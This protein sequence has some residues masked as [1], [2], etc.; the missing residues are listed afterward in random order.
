[1]SLNENSNFWFC[2]VA[3]GIKPTCAMKS[4]KAYVMWFLVELRSIQRCCNAIMS[5]FCFFSVCV[6]GRC[7]KNNGAVL[8]QSNRNISSTIGFIMCDISVWKKCIKA[9][10]A[11]NHI[12]CQYTCQIDV[13]HTARV[14][15]FKVQGCDDPNQH[16]L[17]RAAA[18]HGKV[19]SVHLQTHGSI[20]HAWLSLHL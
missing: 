6:C 15:R 7:G 8:P 19:K 11:L 20:F 18:A 14:K 12:K 2:S 16:P 3:N 5:M 4:W 1:M 13:Q 9:A 10:L 17:M